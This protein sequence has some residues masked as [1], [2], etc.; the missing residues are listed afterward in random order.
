[1]TE[2]ELKEKAKQLEEKF[3]PLSGITA[4][5]KHPALGAD[6]TK[7]EIG[8]ASADRES[9]IEIK[10]RCKEFREYIVIIDVEK[11]IIINDLI[12]GHPDFKGAFLACFNSQVEH[13]IANNYKKITLVAH[14]QDEPYNYEVA[15]R[16]DEGIIWNGHVVWGKYGFQM[17]ETQR[18]KTFVPSMQAHEK[19]EDYIHELYLETDNAS[20][21]KE[22]W[23]DLGLSWGGVFDLGDNSLS[24]QILRGLNGKYAKL[25]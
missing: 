22:V 21:A 4:L 5:Y 13:A 11:K 2:S 14:Y 6:I 7:L 17:K 20:A 3:L 15:G 25:S 12:I 24:H 23:N 18:I 9:K 19:T 8:Y 10:I 1:M 16:D